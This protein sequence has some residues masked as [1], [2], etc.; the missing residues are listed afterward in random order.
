MSAPTNRRKGKSKTETSSD[1]HDL[2]RRPK[3]FL[4]KAEM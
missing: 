2:A 4:T 3:D 1:A